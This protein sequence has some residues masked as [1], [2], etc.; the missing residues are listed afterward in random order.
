MIH[1]EIRTDPRSEPRRREPRLD[2]EASVPLR[3]LGSNGVPARLLNISSGGFMAEIRD[4]IVPGTRVWLTLP[5]GE[6]VN[7]V[8]VW[9]QSGRIGGEFAETIDPL[10]VIQAAG[11]LAGR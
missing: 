11:E 7:A 10:Q 2:V 6:R 9:A 4:Q 1:T 5:D 3:P 8:V